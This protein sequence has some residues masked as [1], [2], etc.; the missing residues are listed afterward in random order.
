MK[1][2]SRIALLVCL[3]GCV[4]S[5]RAVQTIAVM[6]ECLNCTPAQMQ[7]MAKNQP[8]GYHFI[9]DLSHNIIR[10][11]EVYM[12]STCAQQPVIQSWTGAGQQVQAGNGTDCSSFKAA[13]E[14]TPMDTDVQNILDSLHSV[15]L[16][17]PIL[18]NQAK[19]TRQSPP[20]NPNS[21]QPFDLPRAAWDWPSGEGE[22]LRDY[23][24]DDVL[25]SRNSANTFVPGLGDMIY[26][27]SMQVASVSIGS[28]PNVLQ[29]SVAL[30]R[31]N[32]AI[33]FEICNANGDCAKL[34]ANIANGQV[35]SV[36][37]NGVYATGNMQYPSQNG[38]APGQGNFWHFGLGTDA[39]HFGQQLRNNSGVTLPIRP[40]CGGS[41]HYGV[42]VARV[43][44]VVDSI[45][46]SCIPN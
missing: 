14:M 45:T 16:V 41:F 27:V 44:G 5:A 38:Q 40:G 46:W 19:A 2:V 11:Y 24:R 42:T 15:W 32:S 3:G 28:P 13:D 20:V 25:S 4:S 7:T 34:D 31:A 1:L 17:N 18:A 9:Y 29:V 10:K 37:F 33:H 22:D 43:N 36:T 21:G 26:G 12:D 30:D 39:D 23:L 8:L 6:K 35:A